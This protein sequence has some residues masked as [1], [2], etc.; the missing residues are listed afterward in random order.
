[1]VCWSDSVAAV[2][3]R[4]S[5]EPPHKK[6]QPGRLR[7]QEAKL[8]SMC[9][10]CQICSGVER[11]WR[12]NEEHGSHE[13]KRCTDYQD[14]KSVSTSHACLLALTRQAYVAF[15]PLEKQFLCCGA[16]ARSRISFSL[17]C[18][19]VENKEYCRY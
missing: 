3:D 2:K 16:V 5:Q 4:R 18:H 10:G 9:H 12:S 7:F 6:T 19:V 14:I 17:S 8:L 1:M 11:L 15:S 13:H